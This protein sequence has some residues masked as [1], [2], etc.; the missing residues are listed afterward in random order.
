M[1]QEPSISM[2]EGRSVA[3]SVEEEFDEAP[4]KIRT[5]EPEPPTVWVAGFW[6]RA[7][8][9]IV[10][11]LIALP[12]AWLFV[13]LATAIVGLALP[14]AP[15]AG[16]DFWVD[17]TLAG[18]PAVWGALGLGATLVFFY[19]AVFHALGGRTPGM[20]LL[21]LRVVDPYGEPPGLVRSVVRSLGYFVCAATL[22][23]GFFWTAFDRE[24]RG[25]H[26]RLAGTFVARRVA[27]S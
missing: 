3:T 20:R 8:A 2:T 14:H 26:D 15:R 25:L 12:V 9:G 24:K 16:I 27:K 10:D 17:L 19:L 21:G 1:D 4:T 13:W 6:R 11:A 18:D 5:S 7:A 23:L 22:G